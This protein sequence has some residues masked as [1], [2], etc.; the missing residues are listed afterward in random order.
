EPTRAAR[1]LLVA[2]GLPTFG[3]AF[4]ISVLTTYGPVVLIR[5]VDSPSKVGALIG[6]EGAFALVVPLLSGTLSDRVH[7]PPARR[8]FPFVLAGCPLVVAGLLLLPFGASVAL[9]AAAVL[10]FF[11]G[12]YLYYPPYR[13]LYADF[14][15][16]GW[17]ARAQASQAILRGAGLGVALLAGGLLLPVWQPLPFTIAAV[18]VVATTLSLA[19]LA[20]LEC[21]DQRRLLPYKAVSLRR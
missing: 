19:P 1:P 11:V 5:L 15:P 13:A 2:L 10:F 14:L 20:R 7:G 3:L 18:T 16:S 21:E 6:A 9:A 8:R 12:Y 4:A 17:Y